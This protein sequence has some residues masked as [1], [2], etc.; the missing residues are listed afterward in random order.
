MKSRYL[1]RVLL[2]GLCIATA[3]LVV[4]YVVLPLCWIGYAYRH[5]AID[6]TP[7]V[8]TT[9]DH[10]PGDPINL[11]L[12]GSELDLRRVMLASGWLVADPLSIKDDLRIAADTV[13]GESYG[14]A[15]VSDLFLWGRKEDVAFEQPVGNDPRKRHHVRFWKS[16]ELD[17][18]SRPAWMGSAS[19][20]KH[21]GLSH[22]TGQITHH[23][24]ADVDAERD[25][26]FE[27][28]R[29]SGGLVSEQEVKNFHT[30]REGRNGGG[31]PWY[32]D[33]SLLIGT[34]AKSSE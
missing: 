11:A 19:Y 16:A 26:L 2:A 25:H 5:P 4:A 18:D 21:V 32:T 15:P 29:A 9:R 10:H 24:A 28:L 33:G 12:I 17:A 1:R 22:T 6:K 7:G 8:T 3:Y 20:D 31:D 27:T 13:L 14:N 23:I 30:I 34:L